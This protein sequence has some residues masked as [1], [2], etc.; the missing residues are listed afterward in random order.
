M[1]AQ[2]HRKIVPLTPNNNNTNNGSNDS[3]KTA[4][5]LLLY[6]IGG[7]DIFREHLPEMVLLMIFSSLLNYQQHTF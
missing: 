4:V 6:D 2:V 7:H 1:Y 3:N 5:E